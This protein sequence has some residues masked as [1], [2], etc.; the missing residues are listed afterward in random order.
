MWRRRLIHAADA[1]VVAVVLLLTVPSSVGLVWLAAGWSTAV[2]GCC[3]V[4]FVAALLAR[5]FRP[6]L[7]FWAS[8]AALLVLL[9]LP[10]LPDGPSM[11]LL[12]VSLVHV[13]VVHAVVAETGRWRLPFM[14]SVVGLC[15]VLGRIALDIPDP[16]SWTAFWVFMPSAAL[17][18]VGS[19]VLGARDWKRHQLQDRRVQDAVSGGT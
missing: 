7:S 14:V 4:V 15:L 2:A 11:V 16:L 13:F 1:F 17:V 12:P 6:W 18:L 8:C 9:L 19:C 3:V 10:S 5:R